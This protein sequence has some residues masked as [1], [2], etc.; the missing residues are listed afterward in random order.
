MPKHV[1]VFN[2]GIRPVVFKRDRTGVDAIHPGK[3]KTFNSKVGNAIIDKFKDACSEN[4]YE[5]HLKEVAKKQ[6]NDQKKTASET[7]KKTKSTS[8]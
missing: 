8:K 4:D 3:F 5:K 2:K 6:E 1:K 7:K